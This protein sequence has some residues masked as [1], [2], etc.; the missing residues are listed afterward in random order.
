MIQDGLVKAWLGLVSLDGLEGPDPKLVWFRKVIAGI[1]NESWRVL[2]CL[3]YM[4][5][6]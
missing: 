6:C 5:K 2:V 1:V 3:F 4:D